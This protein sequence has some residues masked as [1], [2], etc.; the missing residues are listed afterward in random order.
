MRGGGSFEGPLIFLARK[1]GSCLPAFAVF[2]VSLATLFQSPE[3]ELKRA[4]VQITLVHNGALFLGSG[5]NTHKTSCSF[6]FL[7]IYR[8]SHLQ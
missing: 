7:H 5:R 3:I 1:Q 6:C 2:T 4:N 8:T